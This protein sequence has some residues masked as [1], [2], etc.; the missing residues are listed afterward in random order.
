[1]EFEE[2]KEIIKNYRGKLDKKYLVKEIGIFG[3][4]KR[5]EQDEK[6]DV[7]ILVEFRGDGLNLFQFME[8]KEYLESILGRNV[9]LVT[10]RALKPVMGKRILEEIEYVK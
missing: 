6:S 9:D 8:L 4:F 3:S 2:I 1:M 10:K 7:D 5:N